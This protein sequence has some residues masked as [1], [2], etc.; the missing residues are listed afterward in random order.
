MAGTGIITALL[1]LSLIESYVSGLNRKLRQETTGSQTLFGGNLET[2]LCQNAI[3]RRK[4]P[5]RIRPLENGGKRAYL[6]LLLILSGDVELNPGPSPKCNDCQGNE[7]NLS[8]GDLI[9]CK[10]CELVRFPSKEQA[11]KT[12][13]KPH[14]KRGKRQDPKPTTSKN[15]KREKPLLPQSKITTL[16]SVE[17][18]YNINSCILIPAE[19]PTKFLNK[20]KEQ[21][22]HNYTTSNNHLASTI[23]S[24]YNIIYENMGDEDSFDISWTDL[25]NEKDTLD[26]IAINMSKHDDDWVKI[27][28]HIPSCTVVITGEGL[29]SFKSTILPKIISREQLYFANSNAEKNDQHSTIDLTT[30]IH[31]NETIWKEINAIKRDICSLKALHSASKNCEIQQDNNSHQ[32]NLQNENKRLLKENR[33]LK[34]EIFALRTLINDRQSNYPKQ[35]QPDAPWQKI[36]RNPRNAR[37]PNHP[38]TLNTVKPKSG[39]AWAWETNRYSPLANPPYIMP[40]NTFQTHSAQESMPPHPHIPTTQPPHPHIPATHPPKASN[41][42]PTQQPRPPLNRQAEKN[43]NTHRPTAQQQTT[44]NLSTQQQRETIVIIGD[45]MIKD[46]QLHKLAKTFN[47]WVNKISISG[48]TSMEMKHY[49]QPSLSK[50][51]AAI[52][53]HCGINDMMQSTPLQNIHQ[54]IKAIV[55]NIKSKL[56]NCA[57]FLSSVIHQLKNKNLNT[58]VDQL[59]NTYKNVYDETNV[60]FLDNG[61]ISVDYLNNSRLHLNKRGAA[62]LACNFRDCIK[63]GY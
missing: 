2:Y 35:V 29:E 33:E 44:L 52:I 27:N 39:N 10:P 63:A 14:D 17:K 13:N 54:K 43:D 7:G 5:L 31:P 45:S 22:N 4:F 37:Y 16:N 1:L 46:I 47:A 59:N 57:I 58:S 32:T 26:E 55:N 28:I 49:L 21:A 30:K 12:H 60:N 34:D 11:E 36:N 20:F 18:I 40:L 6:A 8:Q 9:P 38:Q 51:P 53:I 3:T 23:L 56:P 15:E 48:M 50:Q 19:H 61:N 25:I 62:R 41:N 24:F 42:T